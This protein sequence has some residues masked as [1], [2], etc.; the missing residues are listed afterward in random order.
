MPGL[1]VFTAP[2]GYRVSTSLSSVLA[3]AGV[4]LGVVLAAGLLSLALEWWEKHGWFGTGLVAAVAVQYRAFESLAKRP[5]KLTPLDTARLYATFTDFQT[6]FD[7][8]SYAYA[9]RSLR[10]IQQRLAAAGASTAPGELSPAVEPAP[11]AQP[12]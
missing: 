10:Q 6:Y 5:G 8:R 11:G 12:V 9:R 3:G 4:V 7:Q 2:G 1:L